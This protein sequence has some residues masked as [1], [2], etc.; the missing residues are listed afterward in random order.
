MT[1]EAPHAKP[2]FLRHAAEAIANGTFVKLTLGKFRGPDA[3]KKI[4]A[5]LIEV[6]G[7]ERLNLITSLARN[8]VA[9]NFECIRGV[10][11]LGKLLGDT[12]FAATLFTTEKD[13]ELAYNAK[14]EAKLIAKKATFP[15]APPRVHDRAKAYLVDA[16]RPYLKAL[17]VS[18]DKGV[19]KPSMYAKYR[20]ICHFV[21]IAAGLIGEAKLNSKTTI[22]VTDIGAG[23]GYLTFA[24]YDY[25]TGTLNKTANVT[26]VEIR[27]DLVTFCETVAA[28]CKFSN[29]KFEAGAACEKGAR[30]ADMLIALHA[31]DTATDDAIFQGIAGGAE[32]IIVAPCCQHELQ[33]QL[34]KP[35]AALAGL[36]KFGLFKVR[37]AD[38]ITDAARCLLLEAQGYKVKVIEFVST[39]HTAKNILIAG[40]KSS[41]VARDAAQRQYEALKTFAGFDTQRLEALLAEKQ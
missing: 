18:D 7:K 29:L 39:D 35:D 33:P 22:A 12:A 20:Q 21:E 26:G 38:L 24:L 17:G 9:R 3:P 5:T 30:A 10:D 15:A 8:E 14:G 13:Y 4:V 37:Q 28:S 1:A 27:N 34:K 40:L 36:M 31:C 32:I 41:S 11:Q 2:E 25:L 16:S 19:V 23:K 6:K